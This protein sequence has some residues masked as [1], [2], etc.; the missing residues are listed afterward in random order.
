MRRRERKDQG[1]TG[2][3]SWTE[4]TGPVW[5]LEA[6]SQAK[7]KV[8]KNNIA[9]SAQVVSS[10]WVKPCSWSGQRLLECSGAFGMFLPIVYSPRPLRCLLP[11][12]VEADPTPQ[13]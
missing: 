5:E 8:V 1:G 9:S 13:D 11:L 4:G 2:K 6:G 7:D 3:A 12:A 10:R